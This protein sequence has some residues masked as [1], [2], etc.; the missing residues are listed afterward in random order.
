[1]TTTLTFWGTRGSIPT[2]GPTTTRYGGNTACVA[3]GL[4][5][6]HLVVLDAGTGIRA[7]GQDLV[8]RGSRPNRVDILLS[9]TH[10]DHIQGLPFFQPLHHA[11]RT[12]RIYGA[13]QGTVALE[14]I[15]NQ[16][17]APVVFPVPMQK[18]AADIRITEVTEGAFAIGAVRVEAIRLRHPGVTLGYKLIPANGGGTLAYVT[19]NEL[20]QGGDYDVPA[21]WRARLV[22]FLH[23]VETLIHDG[24]FSEE[25]IRARHG[26]GHST[27]RQAVELAIESG[28]PRLVLFHH[29]PA[30]G[31]DAIDRLLADAQSHARRAGTGLSVGA[32]Q[33]GATLTL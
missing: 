17:M 21:D 11:D 29:E 18:L 1:M 10:W 8:H 25:S 26:W 12:V 24:M 31:D 9:H 13:R 3:V 16:Q 20:G 28:V 6:D 19:D 30:N 4:G 5:D 23:G 22:K 14:E 33:E 15:L 27:P 7:L 32:A 2:P